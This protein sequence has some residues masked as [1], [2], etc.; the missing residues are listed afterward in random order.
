MKKISVFFWLLFVVSISAQTKWVIDPMHSNIG[1]KI[2]HMGISLVEGEFNEFNGTITSSK[3]DFSDAQAELTIKTA[4]VNTDVPNRDNHLRSPDFFDAQKYPEIKFSS[5]KIERTFGNNYI[6]S[7]NL[8]M[9]GVTKPISLEVTFLG[10][11]Y[12][13]QMKVQKSGFLVKGVLN[14]DEFGISYNAQMPNGAPMIGRDVKL[15]IS[16]ETIKQ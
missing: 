13:E 7:G 2:S 14:R 10:Q 11:A 6:I 16:L 1:F 9:H 8:T 3:E 5:N 15:N 12:E 4:S